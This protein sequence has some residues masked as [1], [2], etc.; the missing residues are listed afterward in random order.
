M[1]SSVYRANPSL[2]LFLGIPSGLCNYY[3]SLP[4]II[5]LAFFLVNHFSVF[6]SFVS[7]L[8]FLSFYSSV[9]GSRTSSFSLFFF[10]FASLTPSIPEKLRRSRPTF[11]ASYGCSERKDRPTQRQDRPTFPSVYESLVPRSR[12][13]KGRE[14]DPTFPQS[15]RLGGG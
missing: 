15:L 4:Y 6:Q 9:V 12:E 2:H 14:S 10:F 8:P 1:G 7:T 5:D 11:L 13:K 3:V